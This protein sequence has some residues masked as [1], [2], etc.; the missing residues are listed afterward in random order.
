VPDELI[1]Q[2]VTSLGWLIGPGYFTASARREKP[3]E[4][5]FDY[6]R[7]PAHGPPGWPELKRNEVGVS[8][9]IFYQM[10]DYFRPIGTNLG[11]GAAFDA[12]GKLRDQY[13]ALARGEALPFGG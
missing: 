7:Y 3:S 12:D 5:V 4:L 9:L 8:R 6:T 11:I 10:H 1:G 13:F 2:N